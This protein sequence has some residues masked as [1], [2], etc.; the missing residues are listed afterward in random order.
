M[1][2]RDHLPQL[3]G[4]VFLTDGG[5]E[6]T[7]IFHEGVDLSAFAA[8]DL[9]KD[10]EGSTTLRRYLSRWSRSTALSPT[11]RF[12]PMA[13]QYGR[14]TGCHGRFRRG[15]GS[16]ISA[17]GRELGATGALGPVPGPRVAAVGTQT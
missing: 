5:L 9:L 7:L 17:V 14:G 2:Y 4:G 10:D 11:S 13:A 12:P 1:S 16:G 3:D 8:F 15:T 6:T